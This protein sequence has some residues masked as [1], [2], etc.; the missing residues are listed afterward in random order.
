MSVHILVV[1]QHFLMHTQTSIAIKQHDSSIPN[2]MHLLTGGSSQVCYT[3]SSNAQPSKEWLSHFSAFLLGSV[4]AVFRSPATAAQGAR[5]CHEEFVV[6]RGGSSEQ[7]GRNDETY[8]SF[9]YHTVL[10]NYI[11]LFSF[12]YTC[13]P[14]SHVCISTFFVCIFAT[15]GMMYECSLRVFFP[16]YV[17][18]DFLPTVQIAHRNCMIFRSILMLLTCL[19]VWRTPQAHA[20]LCNFSYHIWCRSGDEEAKL[21]PTMKCRGKG[22]PCYDGMS[23]PCSSSPRRGISFQ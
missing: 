16:M 13:V 2:P 10:A 3:V 11:K 21:K 22:L 12:P 17:S 20:R 19:V 14:S 18:H 1:F 7:Q 8:S 23:C 4:L 9:K 5:F 15:P 6:T